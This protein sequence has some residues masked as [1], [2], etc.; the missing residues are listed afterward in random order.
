MLRLIARVLLV[1]SLTLTS[2]T[3]AV[4]HMQA[5]G[6]QQIVLCGQPGEEQTVTLD[7]FGNP[8]TTDHHCP[9]CLAATAASL[10][11]DAVV[12]RPQGR[13]LRQGIA[14]MAAPEPRQGVAPSAR[15]P[16]VAA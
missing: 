7:A 8:V 6:S 15:G 5:A 11:V 14:R 12:E 2:V 4:A 1:L 3:S 10:P 16:P 9:D 13:G